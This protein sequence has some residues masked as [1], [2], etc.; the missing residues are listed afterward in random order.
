MICW[1]LPVRVLVNWSGI[2]LLTHL[3]SPLHV[4]VFSV[5]PPIIS[6]Y[7]VCHHPLGHIPAPHAISA[8]I[9]DS[10][11]PLIMC[12]GLIQRQWQKAFPLRAECFI[13]GSLGAGGQS[14]KSS[15]F[16]NRWEDV[17]K[18]NKTIRVFSI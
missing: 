17:Y 3:G 14:R 16:H 15:C 8:L 13:P 7:T 6:P 12:S 11:L 4:N 1:S 10:P 18:L 2:V 9:E 5:P